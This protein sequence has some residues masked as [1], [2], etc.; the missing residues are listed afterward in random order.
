M[1]GQPNAMFEIHAEARGPHWVAWISRPGQQDP[2]QSV[3]VVGASQQEAESRAREWA[4]RVSAQIE[5]LSSS[6]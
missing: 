5:R 3:L 4:A 6:S 2:Y 1:S